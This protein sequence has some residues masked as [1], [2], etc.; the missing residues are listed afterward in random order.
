MPTLEETT[1]L[2]EATLDATHDGI[3]VVDLNRIIVRCNAQFLRMFRLRADQVVGR[4]ADE[5]FALLADEIEDFDALLANSRQVWRDPS[6]EAIQLIRFRDGRVY[7]RFLAPQTV[8][9]RMVG[10]VASYRDLTE[11]YEEA[12]ELRQRSGFLE[13]AQE[14]AHVGSWVAEHDGGSRLTW[15]AETYRIFGV[16]PG[17]FPGTISAF[18]AFIHP[19]DIDAVR[20]A[21]EIA[22]RC[23]TPYDV[24]H[25]I[26]RGDGVVRWV[27]EKADIVRGKGGAPLRMIGTVQ[28]ITEQR[29]LEEQLR[30]AQRL[31]AIGRLAGGVAHDLNNA[32]TSIVGYTEL[33]LGALDAQQAARRDVE[34]I[35]RAAERAEAVTR[36]LLVF[37]RKQIL[38]PR[39]F[40]VRDSIATLSRMLERL[41]GSAITLRTVTAPDL[42]A[43][44][45]DPGQIEQALINL[46][47]N[48]RDAMPSGGQL[49]L[50][51]A[52]VHVD[53]A[54]AR[55][56]QPIT[57]GDYIEISVSDTGV[58][59]SAEVQTH[60]F[61]PFF[62]TKGVGKGT[63]L[64][65]AMVYGTVKQS[66][67]FIFVDSEEGRG[68]TFRL[69]FPPAPP[70]ERRRSTAAAPAAGTDPA[71]ILVVDDEPAVRTLVVTALK[72]EGYRVLHAGSGGEA[73]SLAAEAPGTINVLLTDA[74]MPGMTGAELAAALAKTRGGLKVLLMSGFTAEPL[75]VAGISEPVA[76]LPKPFT[77]RDLKRK[78][79]EV[80]GAAGQL[81]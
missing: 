19:D 40:S 42:P 49:T 74:S 23:G 10:R 34:E 30:H 60:I 25:R 8:D 24:E 11:T 14:V 29:H 36:Q 43:I 81:E 45:G 63:G 66:G 46:A 37:S 59:M 70:Q 64:G 38:E 4:S 65:L 7:H 27:H 51:A 35:K 39:V 13:K 54:F 16:A 80:L 17:D 72:G 47:V 33:A 21:S 5:T 18:Q 15:S 3:L 20:R 69:Y 73:L 22:R 62:T 71:T 53:A 41:L 50:T 55:A 57:A 1:A 77:P 28:D 52:P 78:V 9:G 32:L 31:E 76:L 12:S 6:T 68:T 79:R 44:Y 56:H 58:G 2:L 26:V 48:A 67:G 61:E 75:R